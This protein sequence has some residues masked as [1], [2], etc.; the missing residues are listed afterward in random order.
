MKGVVSQRDITPTLLSMLQN[1]FDVKTPNEVAWLNTALD[2]SLTFNANTF[3]PLHLIAH[4]LGGIVYKN[5]MLSEGVLEEFT[6]DVPRK[7]NDP[8]VL[9][10]MNRL[11]F[12]YQTLDLYIFNNDALIKNPHAHRN[13]TNVILEMEDSSGQ[14]CM[15]TTNAF[16]LEFFCLKIPEN[17]IEFKVDLEFKYCVKETKDKDGKMMNVILNIAKDGKSASYHFNYLNTDNQWNTYKNTTRYKKEIYASLG[18]GATI[19]AYIWNPEKLEG[20]IDDI[21]VKVT[22]YE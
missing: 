6:D 1:N 19:S 21:K 9:Q 15:D 7:I 14:I 5:Y 3:S 2:T 17:I 8:N 22:V 10:R 4:T 18:N 11:L 20:Y 13:L 12:L 16:P